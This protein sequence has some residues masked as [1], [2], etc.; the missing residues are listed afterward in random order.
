ML[1]ALMI[2]TVAVAGARSGNM[3]LGNNRGAQGIVKMEPLYDLKTCNL[4]DKAGNQH[5]HKEQSHNESLKPE[6]KPFNDESRDGAEHHIEEYAYRQ[7]DACVLKSHQKVFVAQHLLE[8]IQ[9]EPAL[10]RQEQRGY[11]YHVGL[12][13]KG[14]E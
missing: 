12:G 10:W 2:T 9:C 3:I 14:C 13:L 1:M 7:Y 4:S 5:P 11:P 6:I 8:I